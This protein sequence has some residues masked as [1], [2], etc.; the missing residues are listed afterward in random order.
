MDE[1]TEHAEKHCSHLARDG[2]YWRSKMIHV[3]AN[4]EGGPPSFCASRYCLYQ[5]NGI[6]QAIYEAYDIQ[7][8]HTALGRLAQNAKET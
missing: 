7:A 2:Y 8:F 3:L 1:L 6:P 5:S 4:Q